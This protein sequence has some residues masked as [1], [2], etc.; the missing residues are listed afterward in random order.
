MGFFTLHSAGTSL[1]LCS[2]KYTTLQW[3]ACTVSKASSSVLSVSSGT[4]TFALSTRMILGPPRISTGTSRLERPRPTSARLV[5]SVMEMSVVS[6]SGAPGSFVVPSGSTVKPFAASS[7]LSMTKL[8]GIVDV[9][10]TRNLRVLGRPLTTLP[11][12]HSWRLSTGA[13]SSC[14][15]RLRCV[16]PFVVPAVAFSVLSALARFIS[17]LRVSSLSR[18]CFMRRRSTSS[19]TSTFEGAYSLGESF[20]LALGSLDCALAAFEPGL[21]ASETPDVVLMTLTGRPRLAIAVRGGAIFGTAW[22]GPCMTRFCLATSTMFENSSSSGLGSETAST[23]HSPSLTMFTSDG[24][25]CATSKRMRSVMRS[26]TPGIIL[27]LKSCFSPAARW[28]P[29]GEM[30]STAGRVSVLVFTT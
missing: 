6:K 10:C 5:C 2:W 8:I 20:G 23:W 28:P 16:A 25:K 17:A 24:S 7:A 1:G 22:R 29:M 18:N 15:W 14:A 26:G 27:S 11:K 30:S 4:V 9:F 21:E 12:S 3:P 13:A 19:S